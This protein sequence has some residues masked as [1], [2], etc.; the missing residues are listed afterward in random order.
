VDFKK[1]KIEV[2]SFGQLHEVFQDL[3]G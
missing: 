3:F 2:K 1:F